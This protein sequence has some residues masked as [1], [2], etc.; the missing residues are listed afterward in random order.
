MYSKQ[1]V[2]LDISCNVLNGKTGYKFDEDIPASKAERNN[3]GVKY[4]GI[5][6]A[7]LAYESFRLEMFR[8]RIFLRIVQYGP[9]K[10]SV[11]QFVNFIT[12]Q[13]EG[14]KPCILDSSQNG[15]LRDISSE[16][17]V[18]TMLPLGMRYSL[19]TSSSVTA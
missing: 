5:D 4:L 14:C 3:S 18:I 17:T 9:V 15:F 13:P 11:S 1:N 8:L 16:L 7:V 19:Y 12:S 2:F 6:L 10:T